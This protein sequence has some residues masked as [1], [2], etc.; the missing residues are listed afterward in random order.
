MGF[1]PIP[2]RSG[3]H[4]YSESNA[5]AWGISLLAVFVILGC[6]AIIRKSLPLALA[7]SGLLGLSVVLLI[8]R[9]MGDLGSLRG[10][11]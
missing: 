5:L 3:D 4:G 2:D 8:L 11:G 7:F 9:L 6:V 1:C 10:I